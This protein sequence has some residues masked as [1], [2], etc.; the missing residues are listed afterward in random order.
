MHDWTRP[1]QV[2]KPE[3]IEALTSGAYRQ[4]VTAPFEL[5]TR[6]DDGRTYSPEGLIMELAGVPVDYHGFLTPEVHVNNCTTRRPNIVTG[7]LPAWLS[8]PMR[9]ELTWRHTRGDSFEE[10][11]AWLTEGAGSGPVAGTTEPA[12]VAA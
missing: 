12:Q 3:F 1:L 8:F 11:A 10:I 4:N 2:T 7:A 5:V 6:D 9:N